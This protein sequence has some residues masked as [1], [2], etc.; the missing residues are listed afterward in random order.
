MRARAGADR[1]AV[2]L[3]E[4]A[5]TDGETDPGNVVRYGSAHA[6]RA[7]EFRGQRDDE[8]HRQRREDDPGGTCVHLRIVRERAAAV[9]VTGAAVGSPR[10]A[11]QA[12]MRDPTR[13]VLRH[14]R[15]VVVAGR[16]FVMLVCCR[17]GLLHRFRRMGHDARHEGRLQPGCAKQRE[18]HP[19]QGVMPTSYPTQAD[20]HF[21][22]PMV[23]RGEPYP[24][25]TNSRKD[26]C[27]RTAESAEIA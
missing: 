4:P 6:V 25:V 20:R 19:G 24:V 2:L 11:I 16:G 3:E 10:R 22:V 7:D 8:R 13:R 21:P 14:H 26:G 5:V 27:R 18:H 15:G 23:R 12:R 1:E 17:R 9:P